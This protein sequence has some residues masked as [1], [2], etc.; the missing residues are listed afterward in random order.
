MF[1]KVP[2]LQSGS[3]KSPLH[4]LQFSTVLRTRIFCLQ[5]APSSTAAPSTAAV[6]PSA[7]TAVA[8]SAAT[9]ARAATVRPAGG[10]IEPRAGPGATVRRRGGVVSGRKRDVCVRDTVTGEEKP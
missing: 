9:A 3:L 6:A 4:T 8:P 5:P 7:A 1:L 2:D 10:G